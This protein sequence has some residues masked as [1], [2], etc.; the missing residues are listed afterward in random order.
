LVTAAVPVLKTKSRR[1]RS[2]ARP[3]AAASAPVRD[4]AAIPLRPGDHADRPPPA[5]REPARGSRRGRVRVHHPPA[6]GQLPPGR[7]T[8]SSPPWRTGTA[9]AAALTGFSTA[10]TTTSTRWRSSMSP[11]AEMRIALGR[12]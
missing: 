10:S 9:R 4:R 2:W 7:Q 8:A 1:A 6:A 5:H 3:C 11:T 12:W